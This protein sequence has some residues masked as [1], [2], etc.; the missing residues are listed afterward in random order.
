MMET[1]SILTFY[2]L[3]CCMGLLSIS[4]FLGSIVWFSFALGVRSGKTVFLPGDFG[5]SHNSSVPSATDPQSSD[6]LPYKW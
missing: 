5:D 1:W 3:T 2:G 6:L 4:M